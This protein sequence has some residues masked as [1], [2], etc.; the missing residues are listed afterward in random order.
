MPNTTDD[1]QDRARRAVAWVLNLTKDTPLM[2]QRYERHLL[3]EYQR[4]KLSLDEFLQRMEAGVFQL[5]YQSRASTSPDEADHQ[6][7]LASAR[8]YN[9]LHGIT[10]LLVYDNHRYVQVLEGDE[11]QVRALFARIVQDPRHEQ[12]EL[13]SAELVP[14]RCFADWAMDFGQV[15]EAALER[16]LRTWQVPA[17]PHAWEP[18]LQALVEA[19]K[20]L[21]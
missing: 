18:R 4:G 8:I 7:M 20:L 12:V 17:E 10:G 15:D 21:G 16:L 13:L 5:I 2:P 19:Y 3:A 14:R 9:T 1:H 11:P 6:R